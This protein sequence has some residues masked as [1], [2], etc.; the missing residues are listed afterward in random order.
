[1]R[2]S[3]YVRRG[4]QMR[5]LEATIGDITWHPSFGLGWEGEEGGLILSFH[6]FVTL[7]LLLSCGDSAV[8]QATF[9][10]ASFLQ[11]LSSSSCHF[12]VWQL[13]MP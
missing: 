1:M 10:S 2:L 3:D 11:L 13:H 6:S 4:V 5:I 7:L 9:F 12:R 8:D